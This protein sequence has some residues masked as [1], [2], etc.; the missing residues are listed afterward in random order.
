MRRPGPRAGPATPGRHGVGAAPAGS[1]PW[2]RTACAPCQVAA[3]HDRAA[4]GEPCPG[5][6]GGQPSRP[7]PGFCR[8][9][10]AILA[11]PP[12]AGREVAVTG[13]PGLPPRRFAAPLS[14]AVA[15][16]LAVTAALIFVAVV[17]GLAPA[18]SGHQAGTPILVPHPT[19]GP[20]GS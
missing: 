19:S 1:R 8:A 14:A 9:D 20:F 10:A 12:G 18:P 2:R 7:P 15:L 4:H 3:A 5:T 6:G 17:R 13:L 16:V 11:A